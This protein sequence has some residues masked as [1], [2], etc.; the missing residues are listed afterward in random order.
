MLPFTSVSW[1]KTFSRTPWTSDQPVT[2][3]LPNTDI[4]ASSRIWTHDP[5]VQ[6]SEDS[7]CLRPNSHYDWILALITVP[8]FSTLKK[9]LCFLCLTVQNCHLQGVSVS[10]WCVSIKSIPYQP[11]SLRSVLILPSHLRV[12][13]SVCL[14][15][16]MLQP[17]FGASYL[18]HAKY[19]SFDVWRKNTN[20]EAHRYIIWSIFDAKNTF[21]PFYN[22]RSIII[23]H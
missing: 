14:N 3:P 16:K 9:G 7:S 13:F 18:S 4:Y 23:C 12:G 17:K 8:Y 2:R 19:I 11:V 22:F 10:I 6:A 20:Y 1:S 15:P 5:S 21:V